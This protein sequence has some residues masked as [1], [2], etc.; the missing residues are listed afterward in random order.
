MTNIVIVQQDIEN[1]LGSLSYIQIR[2]INGCF[3]VCTVCWN[4][5]HSHMLVMLVAVLPTARL[6]KGSG[7]LNEAEHVLD[8][9]VHESWVLSLDLVPAVHLAQPLPVLQSAYGHM[10]YLYHFASILCTLVYLIP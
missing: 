1:Y 5:L 8:D 3:T 7:D 9:V 10:Q 6:R 4:L 2:L